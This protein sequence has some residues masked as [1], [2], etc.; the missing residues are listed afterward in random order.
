MATDCIKFL[1]TETPT[2]G[3]PGPVLGR[4]WPE[5]KCEWTKIRSYIAWAE[6]SGRLGPDTGHSP[7]VAK[8]QFGV[9]EGA[10]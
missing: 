10:E 4:C 8:P 5:P 3:R 9:G 1:S 6:S 7:R 2:S